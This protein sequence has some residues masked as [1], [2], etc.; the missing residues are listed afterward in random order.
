MQTAS[1]AALDE[2]IAQYTTKI[3]AGFG[4]I[5]GDVQSTFAALIVISLGLS[6]LLWAIDENQNVPAALIRKLLLFGFF[7]WLIASWHALTLTVIRGFVALGLKAGGGGLSVGDLL[8]APSKI[9]WDGLDVVFELLKY[10][11]RLASE[12]MG[13]GFFTH[14]DTIL[15]TA[16]VIIGVLLAFVLLGV[17]VVVTVIEFYAV[18]LISFVM[19]PFGI[20]TQTAFLAE[21]AIAYV[22]AVGVKLMAL[23]LVVS[24]GESLFTN[25]IV[26][27]EPTWQESCGL[28]VAAIVFLMLALKIPA[29][30]AAQITGSPQLSAGSAASS[31]VSLAATAGGLALAG[32][33]AAGGMA[34]GAGAAAAR[35]AAGLR[36]AGPGRG[37]SGGA[38]SGGAGPGPG[39]GGPRPASPAG[40]SP[41][42]V[43][44]RARTW[45]SAPPS[46][47]LAPS[48]PA[49]P[50]GDPAAR[51]DPASPPSPSSSPSPPGRSPATGGGKAAPG[52]FPWREDDSG[53]PI[54]MPP[55][56]PPSD[57]A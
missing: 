8:N 43:V 1:P 19:V 47:P 7:A 16:I 15:V 9:V 12:G 23:A 21:R 30:A 56:H 32:R 28:L 26:S 37:P 18:T 44:S 42:T 55:I 17:E 51:P 40:P 53:P 22:P 13:V 11:G 38:G 36:G 41:Q 52:A 34:A 20:L 27:P 29:V 14:I 10:I 45:F 54:G 2:F 33:W 50:V 31:V 39:G 5:H 4:L 57:D 48:E 35:G 6:A 49:E 46:E 3:G 24:I 25:Y